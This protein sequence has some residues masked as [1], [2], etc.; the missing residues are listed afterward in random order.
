MLALTTRPEQVSVYSQSMSAFS[1]PATEPLPGLSV[2]FPK[3]KRAILSGVF[4]WQSLYRIGRQVVSERYLVLME[5]AAA[6]E[7][8]I[9]TA[10]YGSIG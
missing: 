7:G 2:S 8:R 5:E 6:A 10:P 9:S 1:Y 4:V 3:R